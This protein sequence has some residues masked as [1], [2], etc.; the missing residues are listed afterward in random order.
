VGADIDVNIE[1]S[2]AFADAFY[3]GVQLVASYMEERFDL[4]NSVL[5]KSSTPHRDNAIK[6]LWF[7]ELAWMQ[8]LA[9]LNHARHFQAMATANLALIE[10]TV[11]LLL[12]YTDKSNESGWKIHQWA[13]SEKLRAATNIINYFAPG[14][15]PG[16]F[17]V[18]EN[19]YKNNKVMIEQ[20]RE[21]L[22]GSSRHPPRWTGR[23]NLFEDV[24][25]VDN[26]QGSAINSDLGMPLTQYYR[27]EYSRM[28]WQIHSGLAAVGGVPP[29]IFNVVA[30][31]S[32]KWCAD[33]AMF[34]TKIVLYDFG[35]RDALPRLS[36]EWDK[37]KRDRTMV[38]KEK[39]DPVRQGE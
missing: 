35:L 2:T 26:V 11:D 16:D 5:A 34:C 13:E 12:L 18:Q 3:S 38:Y 1:T 25:E 14:P 20:T 24:K 32:L 27:A 19:F 29:E 8:S 37:V 30:A 9:K 23:A 15:I 21:Q 17:Q 36:T 6:G 33:L 31:L 4:I 22:W 10:M 39:M 28:N 7:R